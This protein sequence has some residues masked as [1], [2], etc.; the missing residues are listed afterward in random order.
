MN[1]LASPIGAHGW[2]HLRGPAAR[3][4]RIPSPD[5]ENGIRIM[6]KFTALAAALIA[7][8]GATAASAQVT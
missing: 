7:A 3:L 6:T 8:T 4:R 1:R 2:A 5:N